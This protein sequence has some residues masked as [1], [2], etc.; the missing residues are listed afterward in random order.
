MPAWSRDTGP[1][2][3]PIAAR[4]VPSAGKSPDFAAFRGPG[5]G[6]AD[7]FGGIPLVNAPKITQI[8]GETREIKMIVPSMNPYAV[9]LIAATQPHVVAAA[10]PAQAATARPV[11]PSP[12]KDEPRARDKRDRDLPEKRDGER[13]AK[14]DLVV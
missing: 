1:P 7:R 14:T 11:M 9:S 2:Y 3:N 6:H 4:P 10:A 5:R 13:G 8:Y 12:K